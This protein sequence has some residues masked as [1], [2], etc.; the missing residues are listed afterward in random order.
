MS[1]V[2]LFKANDGGTGSETWLTNADG[3]SASLIELFP[4]TGGSGPTL[5]T[6]TL[7]GDLYFGARDPDSG[8]ELFKSDGTISGTGLF[9]D[10]EFG[11]DDSSPLTASLTASKVIGET[12][13]FT[14]YDGS[15]GST[16]TGRELYKTTSDGPPEMVR[17]VY[18]GSTSSIPSYFV[19][20][21]GKLLFSARDGISGRELYTSDG[22]EAGTQRV[23]DI[24]SGAGD[25]SPFMYQSNILNGNLFFSAYDSTDGRELWKTD[26]TAAGTV[27]VRDINP[28]GA[29]DSNPSRMMELNGTLYFAADD[30]T[31]G[32]ELWRTDGTEAGTNIVTNINTTAGDGSNISRLAK[33]D[34]ALLFF[35]DNGSNGQELWT[36]DGTAS[37]TTLVRNINPAGNGFVG[38]VNPDGD[39]IINFKGKGYFIA[40]DNSNGQELWVT[41]GTAAGTRMFMDIDPVG[42]SAPR[43]LMVADDLMYFSADD[44]TTGRE[45]WVTDGTEAGTH[46]VQD[47]RVG[48]NGSGAT[49]LGVI[50]INVAP[51]AA[52][53]SSD[54]TP[55]NGAVGTTVGT[56]AAVDADGDAL[57]YTLTNDAGGRFAINGDLLV[58]A[59]ALDFETAQSHSVTVQAADPSG[60]TSSQT[61]T[62]NV[63]NVVE[64]PSAPA[65]SGNMVTENSATGTTVGT[66]SAANPEGG[67]VTFSLVNNAN[68]LFTL[69]GA[70]LQT[71]GNID[72]EAG[73]T[74]SVTVRATGANNTFTDSTF[75]VSVMDVNEAPGAPVL[76]G[77]TVAENAA[78][79]TVGTLSAMD[80]DGDAVTFMLSD[81]ANGAF[82]LNGNTLQTTTG[83]DFEQSATQSVTVQARDAGG[84][85]SSQTFT[86]NVTDV[87]EVVSTVGVTL[88]GTNAAENLTGTAR[89]DL[90]AGGGGND[91]L[92]G[93]E[94][95]DTLRGDDG[96]DNLVGGA[97]DDLLVGG[98]SENDRRDNLF[99]GAGNDTI[100]GGYGNDEVRGDAGDDV[101][102]GGFGGDTVIGGTGNDSI[103]GSALGDLLFGSDGDDFING[104]FGFDQINGG[105]GADEFFHLGVADHGTDFIQDYDAAEGDVLVVGIAG[106]TASDFQVNFAARPASG[107][108]SVEEAFVIYK[109]TEQILFALID[110]GGQS[111]INIQLQGNVFDLLA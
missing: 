66:V 97:G 11:P 21:G 110:G 63:S 52:T 78:G 102:S 71:A 13:Y 62:V 70:Q 67:A 82:T 95:N 28:F 43:N 111:E 60:A 61:F 98:E 29:G 84:L 50:D 1:S 48:P 3:T 44:G 83:L 45:L 36:S 10:I 94:G 22:T 108:A 16:Y 92:I 37:G 55:E 88:I 68:G 85:T 14:A 103:T 24:E 33:L 107:L 106:A 105:N 4:G 40:D 93:L 101:V 7:D 46:Q 9:A 99:G 91:T 18:N 86:I 56:L 76:S 35:A 74:Q 54:T 17:D 2:L 39:H 34:D 79:A 96:T 6:Q 49:A 65:L 27:Q 8:Y 5:H 25:S 87:D 47:V 100:R 42:G 23:I 53:L 104:G 19:D 58:T 20:L 32:S 15:A 77:N 38:A 26:G 72:F 89:D 90:L 64:A 109:P 30:G 59:Q 41:D 51:E 81:N 73:A 75:T 12:M 31:N 80:P 57:T 69:N